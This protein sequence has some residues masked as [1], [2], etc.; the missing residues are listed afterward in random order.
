MCV[1]IFS[2]NLYEAFIILKVT[3]R[4]MVKNVYWSSCK[5]S[6]SCQLLVKLEFCR[7]MFKKYARLNFMKS[8]SSVRPVISWGP[9]DEQTDLTKVIVAFRNFTKAPTNY[10]RIQKQKMV[11]IMRSQEFQEIYSS[12]NIIRLCKKGDSEV[13]HELAFLTFVAFLPFRAFLPSAHAVF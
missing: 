5:V 8:L 2:T 4:D 10:F 12:S 13:L 3:E 9:V 6:H 1:L 7:K 11:A